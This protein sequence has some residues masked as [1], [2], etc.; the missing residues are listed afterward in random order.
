MSKL[1]TVQV[2]KMSIAFRAKYRLEQG[3]TPTLK[4]YTPALAVPHPKNRGGDAVRSIRTIELSGDITRDGCDPIEAN[5]NAVAVEANPNARVGATFQAFFEKQIVADPDMAAKVMNITALIGTLSHGHLN[6]SLRN[7]QGGMRGCECPSTVVET[8]GQTA[9]RCKNK[10]ILGEKGC[11]SLDLVREHDAAWADIIQGG[12]SWEMLSYKMDVEEPEAA[13]AISVALNK[14]NEASMKTSHTEMMNTLVG[15]CKPSP[16]D[17]EGKV[18]FGP[19]RDKLVEFY[20]CAVDH[21]DLLHAFRVVMD[22]G[23]HDSPHMA[24]LQEFTTIYVNPKVR[25]MRFEAYAVVSGYPIELP[26]VKNASLKWAWKQ[27]PKR[28]WCELPIS[29]AHRFTGTFSMFSLVREIEEAFGFLAKAVSTVVEARDQKSKTKW[30]SEVEIDIMTKLFAVPKKD[31]RGASVSEQE[32]ALRKECAILLA[33]KAVHST[34]P[35][36]Q[37]LFEFSQ[38]IPALNSLLHQVKQYVTDAEFIRAAR[39]PKIEESTV[40]ESLVPKVIQLDRDGNPISRHEVL[41]VGKKEDAEVIDCAPWLGAQGGSRMIGQAKA[42]AFSSVCVMKQRQDVVGIA[43]IRKGTKLSVKA[44]RTIEIGALRVPLGLKSVSSL[45]AVAA[46]DEGVTLHPHAVAASVSWPVSEKE[47]S[48]GV[49]HEAHTVELK[50]QP[51]VNLPKPSKDGAK[52]LQWAPQH[53]ADYFWLIRRQDKEAD[54]WNCQVQLRDATHVVAVPHV[55]KPAWKADALTE[56][57]SLRVPHIV[58]TARIKPDQEVILRWQ[59]VAKQKRADKGVTWVDEV[60]KSERKRAK[61]KVQ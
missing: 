35:R 3:P 13:M 22:A 20:G 60:S 26:R 37:A 14:K 43:V 55:E 51:D 52:H 56:T 27:T 32:A 5:A 48:A 18:P 31:D 50:A 16:Q 46:H 11:Y 17:L 19:V 57:Y 34:Y 39:E 24:D 4:Y 49:E 23:G 38:M 2:I 36:T 53:S 61:S 6:C 58:N 41:T 45:V 29:I 9:C 44:T 28:G 25:K 15:L 30:V 47:K 59:V 7:I 42:L 21:P 10:P 1:S 8:Q 12:I 54:E 40:V 33:K